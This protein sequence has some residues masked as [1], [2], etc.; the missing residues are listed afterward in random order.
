MNSLFRLTWITAFS[1]AILLSAVACGEISGPP[2]YFPHPDPFGPAVQSDEQAFVVDTVLTDLKQPW[3]MVFLPDGRLL[4]TE[5]EGGIRVVEGG[6][7][8][9][10]SL[11]GD[12]PGGLRGIVLHPDF[13]DNGLVYVSHY[14]EPTNE[15]RSNGSAN[16]FR[17]RLDGNRLL[18]VEEIY[19]TGP[20]QGGGGWTGSRLQFDKERYLYILVGIRGDRMNAQ[21]RTHYSGKTMRLR[22]D[23]SIPDDNPFVD[24][25]GALPEIY[26]Y[27]HREH[28]GVTL[29]PVTGEV[30]TNEHGEYG[31]DEL[32]IL[33]KG[34]NYGWPLATYSLEYDGT[35]VTPDTLLPGKE[36]PVHHWTPAI[37]P[38]GMDFNRSHRY[39]GWSEDLFI[40]SLIQRRLNRTIIRNGEIVGDEP[41]LESIGRVRDVKVAPDG[42]IYL[43]TEDTG[44][45]VRLIPVPQIR[46]YNGVQ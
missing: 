36:P 20:L 39:P 27:G 46:R 15:D 25:E 19:R 6:E 10:E 21:D 11:G 30:W 9:S 22:D 40:G 13:D 34:G 37:A 23:G 2:S 42:L 41:L 14:V 3:G 4:I 29:H 24:D 7:L 16:V 26:T 18:D 1:T 28:Q 32:N 43:I 12:Y 8:R 33:K 5:R 45:M 17:G 44:L 35:P 31:G 38:S